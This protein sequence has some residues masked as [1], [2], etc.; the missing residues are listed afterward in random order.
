MCIILVDYDSRVEA[1]QA[2]LRA[3][4]VPAWDSLAPIPGTLGADLYLDARVQDATYTA[5]LG[6]F[7]HTDNVTGIIASPPN[8]SLAC[9]RSVYGLTTAAALQQSLSP[10][11]GDSM[12]VNA[13]P[14]FDS[15]S[16]AG[17]LSLG[18][19][20]IRTMPV[21]SLVFLADSDMYVRPGWFEEMLAFTIPGKQ[22]YF[23]IVWSACYGANVTTFPVIKSHPSGKESRGW[24]REKG[25]GMVVTY[26]KDMYRCGGYGQNFM[27]RGVYGT[28]DWGLGEWGEI[29]S[30]GASLCLVRRIG[31]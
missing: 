19:A 3:T 7:V 11:S 12:I 27:D 28:E 9:E 31:G 5:L 2:D 25:T 6:T 13:T 30:Q 22:V 17:L 23:P 10:Y 21:E 26:M 24:W 15:F 1:I 20:S 18:M 8:A 29:V 4:C 14:Y 16:R